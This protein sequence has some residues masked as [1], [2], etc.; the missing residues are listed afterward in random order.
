MNDTN[1][2]Y[3]FTCRYTRIRTLVV[4]FI[5][6]GSFTLQNIVVG[7][8]PTYPQSHSSLIDT[9]SGNCSVR[10]STSPAAIV[11]RCVGCSGWLSR[12]K[13]IVILIMHTPLLDLPI[14]VTIHNTGYIIHNTLYR[15]NLQVNSPS[16]VCSNSYYLYRPRT[17]CFLLRLMVK[18]QTFE[19]NKT[20]ENNQFLL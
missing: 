15:C 19:H 6:D 9:L 14:R 4:F 20:A 11:Y 5:H 1:M 13:N 10:K 8:L 3:L 7:I 17:K 16:D 18:Q 12:E 2:N